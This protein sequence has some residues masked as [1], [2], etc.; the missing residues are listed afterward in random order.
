MKTEHVEGKNKG[1]ILLFAL[2]TCVWC[3]KTKELLKE[4]GVEYSYVYVDLLSGKELDDTEKQ[5]KKWNPSCTFPT[6]VFDHKDCIV[7][8]QKEEIEERLRK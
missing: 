5:L 3:R 4:L 1:D 2:S 7:G 8:Y 6:V